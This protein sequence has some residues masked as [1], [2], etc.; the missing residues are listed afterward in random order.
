[1]YIPDLV[2]GTFE[3]TGGVLYWMNVV[4]LYKD[5]EVK[6]VFWPVQAF[7]SVWG[8]WNIF[9]YSGLDQWASFFGGIFFCAGNITWTIMAAYYSRIINVGK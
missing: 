6:G 1:M 8:I 9:Y 3:T 7:F 4:R 2:N 5:K